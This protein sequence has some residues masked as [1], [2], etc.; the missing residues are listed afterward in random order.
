MIQ[1][2]HCQA[3]VQPWGLLVH[4]N[5][6]CKAHTKAVTDALEKRRERIAEHSAALASSPT[7]DDPA[8]SPKHIDT[9]SNQSDPSID[10]VNLSL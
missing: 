8:E 4:I 1:C 6:W 5:R 9:P 7:L 2:P 3:E 10:E